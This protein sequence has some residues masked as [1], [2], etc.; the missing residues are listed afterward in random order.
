MSRWEPGIRE[1]LQEAALTLFDEQGFEKTTVTEIAESVGVNRRTFFRNFADKRDVLFSY[2]ETLQGQLCDAIAEAPTELSPLDA[3]AAA[4]TNL[5][6]LVAPRQYLRQRQAVIAA[7]PELT[8]RE[9]IKYESLATAFNEGLRRRGVVDS[10]GV[11]AAQAGVTIFRTA[12]E[13]WISPEN[14]EDMS[15]IVQEVLSRFRYAVMPF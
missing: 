3:I 14:H 13:R 1:R 15:L 11:L 12:F 6:K 8:E 9:L 7:S 2:V 5:D 4:L 10:V